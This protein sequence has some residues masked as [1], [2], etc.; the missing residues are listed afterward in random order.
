MANKQHYKYMIEVDSPVW[1]RKLADE[2]ENTLRLAGHVISVTDL[3]N[4]GHIYGSTYT[5]EQGR[6]G[7]PWLRSQ[8]A[9]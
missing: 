7:I 8:L 2:L 4:D 6:R 5:L 3:Q 9:A 1:P